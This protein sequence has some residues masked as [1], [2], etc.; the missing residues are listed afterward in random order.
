MTEA[1]LVE[2]VS[3]VRR[4]ASV[5]SDVNLS[6]AEGEIVALFGPSGSGKTTLLR[7]ILGLETPEH[8]KVSIGGKLVTRDQVRLEPPEDRN[9]AVVF[10]DLALWPH[11]TVRGN[12]D[13]GLAA[14]GMPRSERKDRISQM[15]ARVGL[16]E[17]GE[18]HP[19][20]LSGGEQQRVAIARALVLDPH[21]VLLDEPL[22]N[23]D[24]ALKRE[25]LALFEGLFAERKSTVIY[26]THDPREASVLATRF[27]VLEQGRL[28]QIG[29]IEELRA[30]PATPFVRTL[31]EELRTISPATAERRRG[32]M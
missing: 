10:Q 3:V 6:I 29:A 32:E 28:T 16:A 19:A 22:A 2:H 17:K 8:G 27:A 18:R 9:V 23:I 11:L 7:V 21:A 26:V 15:L 5:L 13:F 14:K 31:M 25:I 24:V 4:G 12:L 1:L 30:S 20:Q